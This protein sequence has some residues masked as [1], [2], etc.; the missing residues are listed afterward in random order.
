[1]VASRAEAAAAVSLNLERGFLM[2]RQQLEGAA[3]LKP[4]VLDDLLE[5]PDMRRWQVE[6]LGERLLN[7]LK[8]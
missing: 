7:V 6:A 5:I 2:P 3:R 8:R 1:M 4:S